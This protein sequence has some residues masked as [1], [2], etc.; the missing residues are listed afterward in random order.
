VNGPAL[1]CGNRISAGQRN[2]SSLDHTSTALPTVGQQIRSASWRVAA[3][4]WSHYGPPSVRDFTGT[5]TGF[6]MPFGADSQYVPP[7]SAHVVHYREN[8][9]AVLGFVPRLSGAR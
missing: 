1:T 9:R 3:D 4:L 5:I 6:H 2:I 8:L 7:G